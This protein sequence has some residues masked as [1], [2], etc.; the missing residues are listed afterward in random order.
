MEGDLQASVQEI[1]K[2]LDWMQTAAPAFVNEEVISQQVSIYL[3]LKRLA[4]AQSALKAYGFEFE[5]NFSHPELAP[6]A[7]I[8]HALGMLYN[9]A[10]H[11]LLCQGAAQDD[12][13][14]FRHGIELAGLVIEGSLRCRHLPIVLKTLLLRSQ[15]HAALGNEQAALV[16]VTRALELSEPE[17]FVS[18]FIEERPHTAEALKSLL[19]R[20]LVGG[21]AE[22]YIQDILTAFPKSQSPSVDFTAR[23]PA[24]VVATPIE[25]PMALVEP[26]TTRELE[27]LHLIAAGDSNRAI[28][29]TLVITVSAVKKHTGNI[30]GKLNVNSRTQAVAR[31]RELRLLPVDG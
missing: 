2:A 22:D 19:E 23:V 5:G 25:N 20:R 11:I 30:Y 9:S 15:L 10:L 17:G 29:E 7:S 21:V 18:I 24:D 3:A 4:A 14:V 31:A 27:V 13:E 26:L 12:P 16:D 1:E 6:E 8:P 28:A